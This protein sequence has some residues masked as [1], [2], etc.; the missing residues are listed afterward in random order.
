MRDDILYIVVWDST[1][2][3]RISQLRCTFASSIA[4]HS[5]IVLA[6][7]H[8]YDLYCRGSQTDQIYIADNP[9][10]TLPPI[11]SAKKAHES[12]TR[13]FTFNIIIYLKS[14]W[15]NPFLNISNA[16]YQV[17]LQYMPK[18]NRSNC[19][20]S[21][22]ADLR[23]GLIRRSAP[24]RI[25]RTTPGRKWAHPASKYTCILGILALSQYTKHAH[26]TK[27]ITTL[28]LWYYNVYLRLRCCHNYVYYARH[29]VVQF[30]LRIHSKSVLVA[31]IWVATKY[32]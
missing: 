10:W 23:P 19:A 32:F 17:D 18:A 7:D 27:C 24:G 22:S 2:N 11:M 9:V 8:W 3:W 25:C 26:K 13:S 5:L 21:S 16:P 12:D 14:C 15:T 30:M 29:Y 1:F 6:N 20:Q 28:Q 4:I 31:S